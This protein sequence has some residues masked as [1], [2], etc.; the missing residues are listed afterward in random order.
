MLLHSVCLILLMPLQELLDLKSEPLKFLKI[1]NDST[2][3]D[4]DHCH[5]EP[6]VSPQSNGSVLPSGL[7]SSGSVLPHELQSR[8][9]VTLSVSHLSAKWTDVSGCCEVHRS[10]PEST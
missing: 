3:T 2:E 6:P 7:P 9:D 1:M 4:G 10:E 8:Q 5:R